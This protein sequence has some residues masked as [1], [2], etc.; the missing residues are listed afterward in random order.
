M[1]SETCLECQIGYNLENGKCSIDKTVS[2]HNIPYCQVA[3]NQSYCKLCTSGFYP[4]NGVCYQVSSNCGS[5][6]PLTGKCLTCK[7]TYI[8]VGG[9]CIFPAMGQ[10]S[11]CYKYQGVYCSKCVDG[12]YLKDYRCRLIDPKCLNFDFSIKQCLECSQGVP[13]F[14][15]C[16]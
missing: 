7:E 8:L 15:L 6:E 5:Y 2:N 11:F 12:Y 4:R 9:S 1:G 10:D 13:L 14:D 3:S 16:Q